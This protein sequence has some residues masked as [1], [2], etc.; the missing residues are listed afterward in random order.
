MTK[1]ITLLLSIFFIGLICSCDS[2]RKINPDTYIYFRKG[3]DT[4]IAPQRSTII[5]TGDIISIRVFSSTAN[6]EQAAIFNIPN[7]DKSAAPGG[8]QVN[9]TGNIDMPIIGSVKAAGLTGIQ[10]Q[11]LL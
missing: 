10:L 5:Q 8:Y 11:D 2:T 4:V 6:Q 3:S 9:E 7:S 1:Y